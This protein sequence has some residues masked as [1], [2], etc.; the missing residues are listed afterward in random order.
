MRTIEVSHQ[1]TGYISATGATLYL[2][3]EGEKFFAGTAAL[4]QAVELRKLMD[5]LLG[6]GIKEDQV[7]IESIFAEVHKGLLSK[8]SRAKYSLF[9]ECKDSAVIPGILDTVTNQKDCTLNRLQWDYSDNEETINGWIKAGTEKVRQRAVVMAAAAGSEIVGINSLKVD[10]V[11]P[12]APTAH[13]HRSVDVM[14]MV[15]APPRARASASIPGAA[16]SLAGLEVAPRKQLA[17]HI[18]AIFEVK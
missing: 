5:G 17:A 10:V 2:T 8:S 15:S 14:P 4:K 11:D 12:S 3:I 6:C 7:G 16:E 9:V 13:Y 1:E 18:H